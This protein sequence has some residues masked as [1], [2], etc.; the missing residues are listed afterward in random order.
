M[1]ASEEEINQIENIG[2]VVSKSLYDYFQQ[3]ENRHYSDKLIKNGV[4]IQKPKI[5]SRQ[6]KFSGKTFVVTGTLDT[7]SRD[8]AKKKIKELGGKV[9]AAVSK[10]TDYVVVGSDPGSKFEKAQELGVEILD[11]DKFL[12]LIK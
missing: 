4:L 11:E 7:L 12:Q 5:S 1:A 9:A 2:P 8:E 3:K 6:Q 10:N